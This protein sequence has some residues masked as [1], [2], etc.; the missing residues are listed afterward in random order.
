MCVEARFPKQ[1][2][3]LNP[4]LSLPPSLDTSLFRLLVPLLHPCV[5]DGGPNFLTLSSSPCPPPHTQH[6]HHT[7]HTG[8]THITHHTQHTHHTHCTH[9]LHTQHMAPTSHTAH[10]SPTW[11]TQ[12]NTHTSHTIPSMILWL[13]TCNSPDLSTEI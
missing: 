11:S 8:S 7:M 2:S 13:L 12:H 1:L 5:G 4:V 6:T 3:F 9:I 10:T